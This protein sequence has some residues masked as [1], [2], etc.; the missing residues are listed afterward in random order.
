MSWFRMQ[1]SGAVSASGAIIVFVVAFAGVILALTVAV[2]VLKNSSFLPPEFVLPLL[3]VGSISVLMIG[4]ASM[5][6]IFRRLGLYDYREAMGLP[7]GSIRAIIALMLI[8]IFAVVSVFLISNADTQ[9]RRVLHDLTLDQ[10]DS[11]PLTDIVSRERTSGTSDADARYRVVL[12]AGDRPSAEMSQQLMTTLGTLVVAVAAFYFG[13]QSVIAA[14]KSRKTT[15]TTV[16]TAP[17]DGAPPAE[18]KPGAPKPSAPKPSAPVPG[19]PV[20]GAPAPGAPAPGGPTP[21]RPPSGE[22]EPGEP[23]PGTP[24]PGK[25]KPQ[26]PHTPPP[27]PDAPEETEPAPEAPPRAPAP[28][29][30]DD[31]PSDV[32]EPLEPPAPPPGRPPRDERRPPSLPPDEGSEPPGEGM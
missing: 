3:V 9:D 6:I 13:S 12:E 1:R 31:D 25:P 5:A 27:P 28:P 30:A 7:E 21:H 2:V 4:L 19:A 22:P 8:V 32:D 11:L 16:S 17:G 29:P 23:T 26:M 24:D 20:P 15:A 14:Q 18:P 10:A